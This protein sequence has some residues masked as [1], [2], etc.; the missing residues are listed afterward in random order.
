MMTLYEDLRLALRQIYGALGLSGTAATLVSLVA[1]GVA[2]N[3]AA[4][5]AMEYMRNEKHP[6]HRHTVL[7]SAVQTEMKVMRTV[8]T[9][10]LKK[11][12]DGKRRWCVAQKWLMDRQTE[13]TGYHVEGGFVWA[14]PSASE[15]C[16]VTIANSPGR[17]TAIAFV[18]C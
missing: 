14:A 7:Q 16:D 4:L 13:V 10:T 1:L 6:G 12:S 17:K 18:Q 11:I 5:S 15:G 2:L 3:I 9:S 8:L